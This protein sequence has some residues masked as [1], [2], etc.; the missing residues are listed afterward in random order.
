[1]Y[2][3]KPLSD[4]EEKIIV[5]PKNNNNDCLKIQI[6]RSGPKIVMLHN[7]NIVSSLQTLVLVTSDSNWDCTWDNMNNFPLIYHFLIKI[8][9]CTCK[10]VDFEYKWIFQRILFKYLIKTRVSSQL[11]YW[12]NFIIL[13]TAQL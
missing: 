2:V 9:V 7:L 6:S 13:T 3:N 5:Y 11:K 4:I 12:L 1:M 10:V 8:I